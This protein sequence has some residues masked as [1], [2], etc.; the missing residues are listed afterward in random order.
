MIQSMLGGPVS[1]VQIPHSGSRPTRFPT[2]L[3]LGAS[4]AYLWAAL[5]PLRTLTVAGVQLSDIALIIAAILFALGAGQ[6]GLALGLPALL[7]TFV[8]LGLAASIWASSAGAFDQIESLS[9]ALQFSIALLLVAFVLLFASAVRNGVHNIVL[10]Y[11]VGATALGV[12]VLVL[13]NEV[14]GRS[15]GLAGHPVEVG[16]SLGVAVAYLSVRLIRQ[17]RRALLLSPP[18]LI[19]VSAILAAEAATGLVAAVLGIV[20][21]LLMD[22]RAVRG[23]LFGVLGIGLA[24]VI[25]STSAVG[26]ELLAKMTTSFEGGLQTTSSDLASVST[27]QSRWVTIQVGLERAL[28]AP[29]FG[30]GFDESGQRVV[31]KLAPHNVLVLA[32]VSGGV[33]P[34]LLLV[35]LLVFSVATALQIRRGAPHLNWSGADAAV[36]A[37]VAA[38]WAAALSGPQMY[39]RSWLLFALV[40]PMLWLGSACARSRISVESK[41]KAGPDH[42]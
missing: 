15:V 1:R 8:V 39:Q 32:W 20:V 9:Q 13:P 25:V 24:Y 4:V 36:V 11:S 5:T 28:E 17:P 42:G 40:L 16:G 35:T 27:L 22:K 37:G 2:F 26:V 18:I 10:A 19:M 23:V 34:L 12:S 21:G 7:A 30:H 33:I 14:A 3:S 38:A 6:S 31:E 29:W 41:Q